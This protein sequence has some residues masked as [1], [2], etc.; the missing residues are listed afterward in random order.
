MLVELLII[1]FLI[2][3]NGLFAMTEF[4]VVSARK[5]RLQCLEQRGNAGA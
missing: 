5:P 4:V 3:A 1:L 2:L